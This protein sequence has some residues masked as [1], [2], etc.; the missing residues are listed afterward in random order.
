ML[1]AISLWLHG[2]AA[3]EFLLTMLISMVP[4]L[5]LRGGVPAGVAMGLP[6]GWR[7]SR[8]CLGICSPCRL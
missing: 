7:C 3:G 1:Q 6:R 4:V 2:T 5:E 8:A